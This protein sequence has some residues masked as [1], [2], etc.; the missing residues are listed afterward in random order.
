MCMDM[1]QQGTASDRARGLRYR[2]L[3]G[4]QRAPKRDGRS[5]RSLRLRT[6]HSEPCGSLHRLNPQRPS[7]A[8]Q[9]SRGD[10]SFQRLCQS[11]PG[12][13][14]SRSSSKCLGAHGAF[15]QVLKETDRA[16]QSGHALRGVCPQ[17]LSDKPG[18]TC[19]IA[20]GTANLVL[21]VSPKRKAGATWARS[22]K[23]VSNAHFPG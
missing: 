3:G 18:R 6:V 4:S 22:G 15:E 19:R 9:R 14:T 11:S 12:I 2:S 17:A 16:I 10:T 5:A 20:T 13:Q 8:C 7:H 21:P 23:F 1:G